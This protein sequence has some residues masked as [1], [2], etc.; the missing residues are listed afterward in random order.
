MVELRNVDD[1]S[2]DFIGARKSWDYDAKQ[3]KPAE[4]VFN[5]AFNYRSHRTGYTPDEATAI[6]R[7]INRVVLVCELLDYYVKDILD[8]K[9]S[10]NIRP[11]VGGRSVIIDI[12]QKTEI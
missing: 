9:K 3:M 2:T 7:L 10:I 5:L 4:V 6:E 11:V 1:E 8:F 12:E